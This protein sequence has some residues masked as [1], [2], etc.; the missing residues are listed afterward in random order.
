MNELHLKIAL[1]YKVPRIT[2]FIEEDIKQIKK[3]NQVLIRL[4]R[5]DKEQYILESVNILRQ[6]EN[7][8]N[9]DLLYPV[10]CELIDIRFHTTILFLYDKLTNPSAT[11]IRKLQEL[12]EDEE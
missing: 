4:E 7:V 12:S 3:L 6:L 11:Y 8:F 1:A 9:L 2:K 10:L 5:N